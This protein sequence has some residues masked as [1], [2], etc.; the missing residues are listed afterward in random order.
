MGKKMRLLTILVFLAMGIVVAFVVNMMVTSWA[1]GLS[2]LIFFILG[3][4]YTERKLL[5][6]W[7]MDL[8]R[9]A[10]LLRQ[11]RENV[12]QFVQPFIMEVE[13]YPDRL[14]ANKSYI[15]I[16]LCWDNRSFQEV[17]VENIRG[18]ISIAGHTPPDNLLNVKDVSLKPFEKQGDPSLI[19]VTITG[20]G[21]G[22][23]EKLRTDGHGRT[24]IATDLKAKIN[25]TD[26]IY[27]II[28]KAQYVD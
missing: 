20:N 5:L 16:G 8:F 19:P 17:R 26:A 3:V 2:G 11:Q 9:A 13:L 7:A 27:N 6:G 18:T 4:V 22:I 1:A 10:R 12:E 28:Y 25:G 15:L 23:I 14:S 24:S 21:L